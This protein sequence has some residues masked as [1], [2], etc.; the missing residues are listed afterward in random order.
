VIWTEQNQVVQ[1]V[2]L[3]LRVLHR[4]VDLKGSTANS[5]STETANTI[6]GFQNG[7]YSFGGNRVSMNP[8]SNEPYF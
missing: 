2:V 1:R 5:I 4:V 3:R 6:R 8:R 7:F